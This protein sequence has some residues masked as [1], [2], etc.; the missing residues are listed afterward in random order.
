MITHATDDYAVMH[1]DEFNFYY[2]Y[3]HTNENG[4]WCFVG[5]IPVLEFQIKVARP[6]MVSL[7]KRSDER[8]VDVLLH[9]AAVTIGNMLAGIRET[10]EKN[11]NTDTTGG[12]EELN[13]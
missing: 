10:I 7:E 6:D 8:P 12:S 2:G 5:E 9:C 1:T 13:L 11:G 4:E 3:E